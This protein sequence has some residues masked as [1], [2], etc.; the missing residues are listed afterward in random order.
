MDIITELQK[1]YSIPRNSRLISYIGQD[2]ERFA[3]FMALYFGPH[4][5]LAEQ[6]SAVVSMCLDAHPELARPYLN[7][8]IG[9]LQVPVPNAVRRN[10]LRLLQHQDIPPQWQGLVA[11]LCFD[12]LASQ[13]PPAT[14]AYALTVLANLARQEPDL[15]QELRLVIEDQLP[16]ATPSFKSRATKILQ[17]M[18]KRHGKGQTSI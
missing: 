9:L 15:N 2:P 17:G 5:R 6:A 3:A 10:T 1:P 4:T 11:D 13:E 16:Y 14:K 18:K 8:L 7:Q 12:Y